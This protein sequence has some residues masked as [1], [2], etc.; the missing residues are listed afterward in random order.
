MR[1]QHGFQHRLHKLVVLLT[2]VLLLV[3]THKD[4]CL[5]IELSEY[6]IFN[7]VICRRIPYEHLRKGSSCL[8]KLL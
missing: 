5:T 6:L 3:P 8:K 7:A 2:L 4:L 1:I